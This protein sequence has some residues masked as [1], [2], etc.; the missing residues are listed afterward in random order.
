MVAEIAFGILGRTAVRLHGKMDVQWGKRR[1]RQVL[2]T[3]LVHAGQQL[4]IDTLIGWVWPEEEFPRN[5]VAALHTN[6]TRIRKALRLAGERA[7]LP[8]A[9]RAYSLDTSPDLV[10][11]HVFQRLV[12]EARTSYQADRVPEAA[13][14][15]DRA[16]G[17][18][19]GRP[20]A[21]LDT[22]YADNWRVHVVRQEWLPAVRLGLDVRI[23]LRDWDRA[24][25]QL[26]ELPTEFTDDTGLAERRMRVL[27]GLGR[28]DEAGQ[29]FYSLYQRLRRENPEDATRLRHCHD[30]LVSTSTTDGRPRA[31]TPP[32]VPGKHHVP[33][34]LP[35]DLRSF[36]GR[37]SLLAE[38]DDRTGITDGTVRP[39]IVILTGLGAVGKTSTAVHWAHRVEHHFP[40]GTLFADLRG[41]SGATRMDTT[42][43][44]DTFLAALEPTIPHPAGPT[45][46]A[47]RLRERLAAQPALVLLDNVRDA[48]HVRSMLPLLARCVVLITS[49]QRLGALA[50]RHGTDPITVPPLTHEH[51]TRML[52]GRLGDRAAI[53]PDD[54]EVLA[55]LCNGIPLALNLVADRAN[56]SPR[57]PL[58]HITNQLLDS[59]TLLRIGDDGDGVDASLH[60]VFSN[61]YEHLDEAEAR[62]FRLLGIHASPEFGVEL[63]AALTGEPSR[64]VA[65]RLDR[66]HAAH[67]VE[68]PD[69][70]D[71]FRLHDLL[72]AYSTTLPTSPSE[73]ARARDRMLSFYLVSA[74]NAQRT[75]FPHRL[76]PTPPPPPPGCVPVTFQHDR[77]AMLWGRRERANLLTTMDRAAETGRH[78]HAWRIAHAIAGLL[79][80][81]GRFDD[82]TAALE[83][84]AASAH[85]AGEP[86]AHAASRNDLGHLALMRDDPDTASDH[87][88]HA[89]RIAREVG[90]PV[91]ICTTTLNIARWQ[92][93]IGEPDN[94]LALL[95]RCALLAAEAGDDDR[96]AVTEHRFGE[97]HTDKGHH[98]KAEHHFHRSLAIRERIGDRSGQVE[99]LTGLAALARQQGD[100]HGAQRYGGRA[101]ELLD[102]VHDITVGMWA[103]AVMAEIEL[104]EGHLSPARQF[105]EEAHRRAATT[106]DELGEARILDLLGR[107][108]H[109]QGEVAAARKAWS[110]AV[111]LLHARGRN[112]AARDIARRLADLPGESGHSLR[113]G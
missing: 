102:P 25:R 18:W 93:H 7:R 59:R 66:L 103:Y 107:A 55:R 22:E 42:E 82:A 80:H 112:T 35:H 91:G 8:R 84:A 62:L 1:E 33:R 61:S 87:F 109:A 65:H 29:F 50:V 46:R 19:R 56:R 69:S 113:H 5:P 90:D 94:A 27:Y 106:G 9:D 12:A 36:A 92:R 88:L 49:R 97:V 48:A 53:E 99:T 40:G 2:A 105:A 38:L 11:Y 6:T 60:A 77:D 45:V 31:G 24:L 23:A 64:E 86:L 79:E 58:R 54:L 110:R 21:D 111:S 14:R 75:V 78:D 3:L 83:T 81:H 89:L 98:S 39:H 28:E 43:M 15:I 104:D 44:V 37:E 85:A 47:E 32:S 51:A 95:H 34:Q 70:L 68:Q 10:D 52:A 13:S 20:L 101:L 4:P 63:A 73:T 72:H 71:R 76:T 96:S 16:L 17:L 41:Y 67:L 74:H 26:D 108:A 30:S 100:R 57:A